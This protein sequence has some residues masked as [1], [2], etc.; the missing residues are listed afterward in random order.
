MGSKLCHRSFYPG[1]PIRIAR[2]C[3]KEPIGRIRN[4]RE[5]GGAAH[6]IK[7]RFLRH[8]RAQAIRLKLKGFLVIAPTHRRANFRGR[9]NRTIGAAQG[10]RQHLKE[11]GTAARQ[12]ILPL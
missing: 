2:V 9:I 11:C 8:L 3:A 5:I 10:C 4:P 6:R 12:F 7:T 1:D